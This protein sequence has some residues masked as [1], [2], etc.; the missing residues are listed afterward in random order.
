MILEYAR[1]WYWKFKQVQVLELYG[2]QRQ[3]I[4][5]ACTLVI[6]EKVAVLRR[7]FPAT[8]MGG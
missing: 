5:A 4:I 7:L 1:Q 2:G 3:T 8:K 6:E